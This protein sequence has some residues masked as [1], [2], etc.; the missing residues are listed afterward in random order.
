MA[1]LP[2]TTVA[3]PRRL[4]VALALGLLLSTQAC[5]YD[6]H[7]NM[8]ATERWVAS[9]ISVIPKVAGTFFIAL[10]DAIIG[11][12]TMTA[13]QL[14]RNPQY[15]PEHKYLSYAGSR[16]IARSNMGHG[17]QWLAGFPTIIIDTVWL[18]VTG[19]I[20]IFW[21]LWS[22]PSETPPTEVE[23]RKSGAKS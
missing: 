1:S 11:P 22:G 7:Q 4:L 3:L 10:F 16:T 15:D 5:V 17:Y 2:R 13:D 9:D 8:G 6:H 14:F 21:V 20:D 19:P 23:L 12:F 18:I